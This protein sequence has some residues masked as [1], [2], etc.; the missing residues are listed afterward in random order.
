M[1]EEILKN[2]EK[3]SAQFFSYTEIAILIKLDE[4][5]FLDEVTDK[6]SEAYKSY[7]RGKL[8]SESEIREQIIKLAKMGSPAAQIEALNLISKQKL[9]EITN[10]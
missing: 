8:I 7:Q 10:A 4:D 1:T 5:S 3:Y 2:I 9:K 6:N